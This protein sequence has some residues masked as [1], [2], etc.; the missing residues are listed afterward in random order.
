M[1]PDEINRLNAEAWAEWTPRFE[2]LVRTLPQTLAR[3]VE[4]QQ[5]KPVIYQDTLEARMFD[6]EA[7]EAESRSASQSAAARNRRPSTETRP[8]FKNGFIKIMRRERRNNITFTKFLE[9]AV[10]DEYWN[11]DGIRLYSYKDDLNDRYGLFDLTCDKE[12]AGRGIVCESYD[13]AE[14]PVKEKVS[15]EGLKTW[16]KEAKG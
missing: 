11:D 8:S 14:N 2:R 5:F 7:V 13:E 15:W 12:S 4:S 9:K 16:W 10:A 3:A 1:T 6:A